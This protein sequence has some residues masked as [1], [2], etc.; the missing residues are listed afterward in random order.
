MRLLIRMDKEAVGVRAATLAQCRL[1][2]KRL[3]WPRVLVTW[4][5]SD[6]NLITRNNVKSFRK[7]GYFQYRSNI[8]YEILI[9]LL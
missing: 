8:N 9:A 7:R 5:V 1:I 6:N 3:P 4:R 2:V